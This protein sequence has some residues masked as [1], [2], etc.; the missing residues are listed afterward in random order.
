VD[1]GTDALEM[2]RR[3]LRIRGFDEAAC[4]LQAEG[5]FPGPL[6]KSTGQEATVVGACAALRAEDAI[7]GTH[8]SHGHPIAKGAALGPL[9]AELLGREAGVC[10][11]KGGSMHL[12]DF[13]V[14]CLGEN[15][16]VGAGLPIA[17][18]IAFAARELRRGSVAL[19]FFG[20]GAAN[21]GAF[22]EA[23]NLA[24]VWKLP[25]VFVCENNRYAATTPMRT[26]TAV[27][28]IADRAGAY[29]MPGHGVDG[30][31]AVAVREVVARAVARARRGDGP[32]LVEALTY[33]F[34]EHADGEPIPSFY[35][36]AAEIERWRAR[37]PLALERARLLQAGASEAELAALA[38]EV[39]REVAQAVAFAKASPLPAP[40]QAFAHVY[41]TPV[42]GP[43]VAEPAEGA[44]ELTMLE[45]I[46]EALRVA[47]AADP[48]VVLLGEDQALLERTPLLA[49]FG[50]RVF[51]TPISEAGFVGLAVGAALAGL[52][53]VVDLTI[54]SFVYMAMDALAN[55]AAKTRYLFGGQ[56]CV[57]LVVRAAM[58]HDASYAAQHSD[59][60][61]PM[62]LG[63]PGLK[64]VV[65]ASP[66]DAKGLLLAAIRDDDPVLFFDD[67]SLWFE[68]GPVP[69]GAA[70]LP[71]GRA[72]VVR[73]GT[74]AT[75]VAI[76]SS[77]RRAAEAADALAAAGI[78]VE[79]LDP[80]TLV[81]LDEE[82]ILASVAKTGHLVVVEP[83]PLTGGAGA[84]IA[85]RVAEHGFGSLRAPIR[86]IAAPDVPI[87][88]SPAL[89][90]PLYPS[91]ARIAAAVRALLGA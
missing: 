72:R 58:W 3:M 19:C 4:A 66:A 5:A 75:L 50:S 43:V 21:E 12:A 1:T 29:A 54:A 39:E 52:R 25:V 46:Y 30:Q 73:S 84:E 69:E 57:P 34:C 38:A 6:H 79:V 36:D 31:D 53:P 65:P 10:H 37:D 44:R 26:T 62:F 33:R 59:R 85:A 35:R 56:A 71:L 42:P 15:A 82:A 90:K 27:E 68:R 89:E 63:V 8:R 20:D 11:G 76:G 47:M 32:S 28:R 70:A 55:Q 74:D 45:A 88:F 86:R 64:V 2:Y 60:P 80:R 91:A 7:T 41:A 77:V 18:G 78:S 23:L 16:I 83:A 81:P 9:M 67:K 40:E 13:S 17:T 61:Y 14:G 51:S 48:R 87:P 22:H 24:S 49:G